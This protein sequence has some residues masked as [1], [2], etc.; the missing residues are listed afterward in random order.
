MS[1]VSFGSLN[2]V[3][4]SGLLI[5]AMFSY[6]DCANTIAVWIILFSSAMTNDSA[7][8]DPAEA[9]SSEIW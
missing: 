2:T 4:P 1:F 3:P 5:T 9:V 8:H 6:A 7:K